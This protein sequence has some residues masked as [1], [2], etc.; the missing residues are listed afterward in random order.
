MM[1]CL[2]LK[3]NT[4]IGLLIFPQNNMKIFQGDSNWVQGCPVWVSSVFIS[5]CHWKSF[6][7][8]CACLNDSIIAVSLEMVQSSIK[9]Y[10]M[11]IPKN[12]AGARFRWVTTQESILHLA[13][14]T[15]VTPVWIADYSPISSTYTLAFTVCLPKSFTFLLETTK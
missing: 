12:M 15:D 7:R 3:Q 13:D 6:R 14:F 4:Y 1:D 11:W 10:I 2:C 5:G 9:R 8:I